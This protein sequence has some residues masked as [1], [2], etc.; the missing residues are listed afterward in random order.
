MKDAGPEMMSI[1]C[2]ALEQSTPEDRAAYLDAACGQDAELRA[3][4]DVLLR[5]HEAASGFLPEHGGS[6]DPRPTIDDTI[7]ERP[8]TLI[9]PYKLLEQI[10]EGS[11]GLVFMAEQQKPIRRIVAFKVLK[12]GMDSRQIIARFEAERQALALMDHLNIAKV[13]DAGQTSSGRPYFVMDLVKGLP[14]TEFCDQ[15]RL[16]TNEP[17]NKVVPTRALEDTQRRASACIT[18]I[19]SWPHGPNLGELFGT[20]APAARCRRLAALD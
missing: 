9:G 19:R 12:P 11:F 13:L 18:S 17:W 5:A 2:G 14:I 8:G 4:V 1:F 16:T 20:P 3:R 10:G 7:T 15:D 6:R